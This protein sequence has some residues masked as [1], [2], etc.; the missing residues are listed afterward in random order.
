[1]FIR[2]QLVFH[3]SFI[4]QKNIPLRAG[5]GVILQNIHPCVIVTKPLQKLEFVINTIMQNRT[6]V[7]KTVRIYVNIDRPPPFWILEK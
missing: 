3:F 7:M 4:F 6:E 1:M 5:R 2:V